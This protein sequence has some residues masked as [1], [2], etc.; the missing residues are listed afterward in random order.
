MKKLTAILT[1]VF[2]LYATVCCADKTPV[3]EA[4][5]PAAAR[6]FIKK[7]F[8]DKKVALAKIDTEFARKSYEVV[9]ADGDYIEFDSKGN[10][11]EIDCKT[12]PVPAA[13]IPAAI[14]SYVKDNYPD[15][16]IRKIEKER[17]EYEV[18]L[19]NRVELTFDLKFRL[20]DIDL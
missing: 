5:L 12:S 20:V 17:R 7:H 19:S 18:R 16:T 10:W 8:P 9:F 4:Q 3:G 1:F 11:E 14:A 6:Q 13:V 15:A 2:A